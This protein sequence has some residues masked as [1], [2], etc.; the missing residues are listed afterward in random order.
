MVS[1]VLW[2]FPFSFLTYFIILSK[3]GKKNKILSKRVGVG[4]GWCIWSFYS[5]Y[6]TCSLRQGF[7]SV[8]KKKKGSIFFYLM[9]LKYLGNC[10]PTSLVHIL[11]QHSLPVFSLAT[12]NHNCDSCQFQLHPQPRSCL[13]DLH[14]WVYTLQCHKSYFSSK[15]FSTSHLTSTK[16]QCWK[17]P[18][19]ASLHFERKR[20]CW[21][22]CWTYYSFKTPGIPYLFW[23]T[24]SQSKLGQRWRNDRVVLAGQTNTFQHHLVTN[25][26]ITEPHELS[27]S[28]SCTLVI[29]G[30]NTYWFFIGCSGPWYKG[31]TCSILHILKSP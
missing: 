11:L 19:V 6:W 22:Y 27:V 5:F 4:C 17:I 15:A 23:R 10:M 14:C 18:C 21:T 7:L 3:Q 2:V 25:W 13:M 30:S 20:S 31:K 26:V 12:F 9:M 8:E 29:L 28:Y 16:R 1:K 24:L